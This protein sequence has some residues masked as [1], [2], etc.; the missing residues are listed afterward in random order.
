MNLIYK[1][2]SISAGGIS[3]EDLENLIHSKSDGSDFVLYIT[4]RHPILSANFYNDY[5]M[6]RHLFMMQPYRDLFART[7]EYNLT[8]DPQYIPTTIYD[9][10]QITWDS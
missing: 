10:G 9:G 7:V 5:Q 4:G 1:G 6:L 3:K 2:E 8:G